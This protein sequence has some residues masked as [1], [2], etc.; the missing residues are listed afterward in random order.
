[1]AHVEVRGIYRGRL[2]SG[3]Q[4]EA[5]FL[6]A[7]LGNASRSSYADPTQRIC[8]SSF[9]R[10]AC[11]RIY[12]RSIAQVNVLYARCQWVGVALSTK[13]CEVGKPTSWDS[14]NCLPLVDAFRTFCLLPEW[15]GK[16]L[17]LQI[18]EVPV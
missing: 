12:T 1:M 11:I 14:K 6:P 13:N 9:I 17:F 5:R 7:S 15:D 16:D 4:L 2:K 3:L 18:Q 10:L 8:F